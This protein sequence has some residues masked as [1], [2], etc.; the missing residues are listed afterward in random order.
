MHGG[1]GALKLSDTLEDAV[2]TVNAQRK[3]C[4]KA[5]EAWRDSEA[6]G[7]TPKGTGPLL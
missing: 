3:R 5:V 2:G 1:R 4:E 7:S 6:K